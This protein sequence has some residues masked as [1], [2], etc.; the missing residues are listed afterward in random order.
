MLTDAQYEELKQIILD[1]PPPVQIINVNDESI[2]ILAV[3]DRIDLSMCKKIEKHFVEVT[4][5][6]KCVCLSNGM[7]VKQVLQRPKTKQSE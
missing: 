4:K 5:A 1:I 6:Y 3:P 2:I 7:K